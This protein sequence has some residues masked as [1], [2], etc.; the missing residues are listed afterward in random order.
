S[1]IAEEQQ[2]VAVAVHMLE[3]DDI[4]LSYGMIHVTH[5]LSQQNVMLT[6]DSDRAIH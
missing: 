4:V 3:Q 6:T 2:D 1:I 5:K